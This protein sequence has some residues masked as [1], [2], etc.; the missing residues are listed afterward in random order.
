[1]DIDEQMG[2]N[3][4]FVQT[5]LWKDQLGLSENGVD[6]ILHKIGIQNPEI[7]FLNQYSNYA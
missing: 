5:K 1:M 2:L 4:T 7:F 6:P 3:Y